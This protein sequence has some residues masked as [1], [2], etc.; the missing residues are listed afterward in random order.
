MR[1]RA[2]VAKAF[3]RTDAISVRDQDSAAL[4]REIGV[5]RDVRVCADPSFL[6][7]PDLDS[8]DTII[9]GAGLSADGTVGV[10]LRPWPGHDDWLAGAARTVTDVC[11]E[12]G[13]QPVFIPM[14]EPEDAAFGEGAVTLSHGGDPRVAKGL[15]A[16][17]SMIVGMRLHSLIFAAA[18]A[19]PFV[20]IIY[21]PKVASF[22]SEMGVA[23][24]EIGDRDS[25]ALAEAIRAAWRDRKAASAEL[26]EKASDLRGS[27]MLPAQIAAELPR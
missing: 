14:Q 13:A 7:E 19:V 21:D 1:V 22:A 23:G 16:R 27:A 25:N 8:A 17:C 9:R 11:R 4:L 18:A 6:V 15:I 12:I 10:S 3:N 2:W 20:P 26:A 24:V 5:T